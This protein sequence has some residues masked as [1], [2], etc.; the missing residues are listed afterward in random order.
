MNRNMSKPMR[1]LVAAVIESSGADAVVIAYSITRRNHSKTFLGVYG[2]SLACA[3]LSEEAFNELCG[4][5]EED[6]A[7]ADDADID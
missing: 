2:N 1:D 6:E 4:E 5:I 7:D 3:A